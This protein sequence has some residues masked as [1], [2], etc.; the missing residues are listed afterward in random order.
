MSKT[1]PIKGRRDSVYNVVAADGMRKL[2]LRIEEQMYHQVRILKG[3]VSQLY[4]TVF[5]KRLKT[6]TAVYKV[7]DIEQKESIPQPIK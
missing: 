5:L 7:L 3:L 1:P 6:S 2:K 4:S